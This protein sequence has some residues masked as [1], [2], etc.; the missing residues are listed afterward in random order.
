M[1]ALRF[2]LGQ[3]DSHFQRCWGLGGGCRAGGGEGGLSTSFWSL[4]VLNPCNPLA[5][6]PPPACP[7]PGILHMVFKNQ[8]KRWVLAYPGFSAV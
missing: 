2:W 6:T 5:F 3:G 4:A 7:L 1:V 8:V